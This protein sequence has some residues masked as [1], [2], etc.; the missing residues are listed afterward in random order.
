MTAETGQSAARGR[1]AAAP[2]SGAPDI[3]RRERTARLRTAAML[4]PAA[5]LALLLLY[6]PLAFIV[7]MSFTVSNSFLSPGGPVYSLE[8]Y[9]AMVGR[10]LPNLFVTIQLAALAMLVDLFLGFPFAYILVRRIRYRDLVRA[11]MVFPMFGALYVAFG[12]SFILLP[13]G[14]ADPIIHALGLRNTDLLFSLPAVVFAMS[15]FTFPF[16]VM[17]IG[18]ALSNVD[19]TLEEAA[20]CLGAR[21]WQ[22]FWRVVLPLT[23]AGVIAGALMV[24][25]WSIGAFAEPLLLGSLNEQRSLA[26]T[27]YKRGVVENDYGLS[28]MMGVVLLS[29]AFTVTYFSLR[30]SRGALVE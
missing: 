18:T 23:R 21:P 27:L 9:A 8:N 26:L 17:S 20:A 5:L 30:Y 15:I 1:L 13:G 11:L 29:L 7:N 3:R 12:M 4:A 19:P 10:Y 25:G 2:L 16:M 6:A 24:F 22:T 14:P 28:S